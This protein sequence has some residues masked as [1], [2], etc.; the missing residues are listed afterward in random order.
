MT[1]RSVPDGWTR[2]DKYHMTNGN[3]SIARVWIGG[4]MKWVLWVGDE[5]TAQAWDDEG[6]FTKMI[7]MSKQRETRRAA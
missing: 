7:E 6:G 2:V 4:R 3:L 1:A 5:F